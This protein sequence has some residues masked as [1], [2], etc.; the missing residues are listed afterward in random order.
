MVRS[1]RS[2]EIV[3]RGRSTDVRVLLPFA[4][5]GSIDLGRHGDE[6]VVTVGSCRRLIALPAA[7][8]SARVSEARL[9]DGVLVVRFENPVVD[10][11]SVAHGAPGD[12]H[13]DE[14]DEHDE[15]DEEVS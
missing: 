2:V 14:H 13:P 10:A 3:R 6:L 4:E 7:L 8:R 9:S 12:R 5:R 15:H 1:V 11:P